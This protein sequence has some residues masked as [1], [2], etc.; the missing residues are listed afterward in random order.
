MALS[1]YRLANGLESGGD[2]N[3]ILDVLTQGREPQFTRNSILNNHCRNS[4]DIQDS[5]SLP[6][7]SD[8]SDL[9][10]PPPYSVATLGMGMHGPDAPMHSSS[11]H[12]PLTTQDGS[13]M[14]SSPPSYQEI[15][16][17]ETLHNSEAKSL[18]ATGS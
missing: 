11:G 15:M 17:K 9:P 6:D 3:I 4:L 14:Y 2:E 16:E 1:I 12:T 10:P 18:D 5:A 8:I 7:E 13:T